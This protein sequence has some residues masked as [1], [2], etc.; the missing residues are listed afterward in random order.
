MRKLN[1]NQEFLCGI[2]NKF[3]FSKNVKIQCPRFVYKSENYIYCVILICHS[4]IWTL[5]YVFFLNLSFHL[6]AHNGFHLNIIIY[7]LVTLSYI[8]GHLVGMKG[9]T[10][11]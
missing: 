7:T 8:V 1:T 11:A 9:N 4:L 6:L 10:Q 2:A 5:I 3:N